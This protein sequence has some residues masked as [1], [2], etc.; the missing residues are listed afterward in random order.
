[1]NILVART[2]S[3]SN[4]VSLTTR[5][6]FDYVRVLLLDSIISLKE[7]DDKASSMCEFHPSQLG[8]LTLSRCK[9]KKKCVWMRIVS[10][11]RGFFLLQEFIL[12]LDTSC[13]CHVASEALTFIVLVYLSGQF[14][15]HV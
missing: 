9:K 5:Y 12:T 2:E 14:L 6:P 13:G 10:N 8:T 4:Y 7:K 11:P 3:E 15:Q 1:M